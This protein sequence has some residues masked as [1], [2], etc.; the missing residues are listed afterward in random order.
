MVQIKKQTLAKI[1]RLQADFES[2]GD[3]MAIIRGLPLDATKFNKPRSNVL[4][5]R[6]SKDAPVFIFVD[7]DLAYTGRG[8]LTRDFAKADCRDGWRG[9]IM[10]TAR[11]ACPDFE[12][13][14]AAVFAALTDADGNA[15]PSD[16]DA[17]AAPALSGLLGSYGE[18]ISSA[19]RASGCPS[20]FV[21]REEL[22]LDV[23]AP[24]LNGE[25]ASLIFPAGASG[26]GKSSLLWGVAE[27]LA[28]CAAI[29]LLR[30]DLSALFAGIVPAERA[31]LLHTLFGEAH[32]VPGAVLI[33]EAFPLAL[34]VPD[35]ALL[36]KSALEAG[37]SV[38]AP[39]SI[40]QAVEI[41]RIAC[42]ERR[43]RVIQVPEP[44]AATTLLILGAHREALA[45]R[46]N[47]E[48]SDAVLAF[49]AD[50]A[51]RLNGNMPAK[52]LALMSEAVCRAHLF[53]SGAIGPEDVL[54]AAKRLGA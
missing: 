43:I 8:R 27:R 37:V 46:F 25:C 30:V 34:T 19:V 17:V 51:G 53:G 4:L 12:S 16:A 26:T 15:P 29:R 52:A 41:R 49:L 39:V 38:V 31:G 18:D 20:W 45:H 50:V 5:A 36:I 35:G 33:L 21:P 11:E 32:T 22:T 23:A 48:V 28:D 1:R 44:D 10:C 47:V 3:A 42:L 14:V 7:E 54:D 13:A 9:P 24:L 40:E 6:V 2:L